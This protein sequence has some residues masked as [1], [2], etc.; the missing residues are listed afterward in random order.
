MDVV[1]T[2]ES[3]FGNLPGYPFAP[4]YVDVKASDTQ[5][6]RMH[7]IDE[8]PRDGPSVVLLHASRPGATSTAP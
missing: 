8:G 3:R 7:Y 6:I 1:R 5:A 2:P 4:H